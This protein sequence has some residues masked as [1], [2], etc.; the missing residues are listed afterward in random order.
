MDSGSGSDARPGEGG[1]VPGGGGS[2]E[3]P[4]G[5]PDD[6]QSN[7]LNAQRDLLIDAKFVDNQVAVGGRASIEFSIRNRSAVSDTNI[8]MTLLVP[9]GLMLIDVVDDLGNPYGVE[10]RSP[11]NTLFLLTPRRE[12]RPNDDINL[13][14]IVAGASPGQGFVELQVTSDNS[15]GTIAASDT[16]SVVET[17]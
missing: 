3:G 10:Q 8:N 13:V 11:D 1:S 14:V 16:I 9:P 17:P 15:A 2:A 5:I 4:I 7:N 6:S 12:M